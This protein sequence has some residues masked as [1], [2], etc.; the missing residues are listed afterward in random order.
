MM[1]SHKN[2]IK[3]EERHKMFLKSYYIPNSELLP[4]NGD[5]KEVLIVQRLG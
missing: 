2:K 3:L 5:K 4:D 1:L